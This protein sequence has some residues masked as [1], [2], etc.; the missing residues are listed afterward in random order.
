MSPSANI[1]RPRRHAQGFTLV[2]VMITATL[3]V[4]ILAGVLATTLLLM[5]SGYRSAS[6]TDMETQARSCLE[7]FGFDVR[8]ANDVTWDSVAP[9]DATTRITLTLPTASGI[10]IA[11]S[12]EYD[13]AAG[14]LT[15]VTPGS[16]EILVS[17]IKP[18]SFELKGF[19]LNTS[20]T[21]EPNP[22]LDPVQTANRPQAALDCKQ[23]EMALTVER[24]RAGAAGSAAKI[25]SARFIL[26]NKQVAI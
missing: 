3:S 20:A 10:D 17:G 8:M 6:Y 4:V 9:T 24:H 2:E 5:R 7:R 19:K 26:R 21:A 23:L 22:V 13:P 1:H 18:G 12:Y 15:R 25:I 11:T 16:A 14:T